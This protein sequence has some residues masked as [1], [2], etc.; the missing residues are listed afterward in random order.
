MPGLYTP[1]APAH[2][3]R[4]VSLGSL[5]TALR[6][7]GGGAITIF[8]LIGLA[9]LGDDLDKWS[10]WLGFLGGRTGWIA[11]TVLGLALLLLPVDA[12][13]RAKKRT[14]F[15]PPEDG[16]PSVEES[17]DGLPKD[18]PEPGL[19]SEPEPAVKSL[20]GQER[21]PSAERRIVDVTPQYL[22]GLF[23]SYTS[24]QAN[25]LAKP[26]IGKW[27]KVSGTLRN[28]GSFTSFSQV[29]FESKL[30]DAVVFMLFRDEDYVANRL[31]VLKKGDRITV[32]GQID[33]V[34]P[35]AVQ[36]DDCELID[37]EQ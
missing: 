2:Y 6:R 13:A 36:L 14:G 3:Y 20:S 22:A 29:T 26:F 27:M 5:V 34:E 12:L 30:G 15:T 25:S 16:R 24:I 8:G 17:S 1:R 21:A 28:V 23:E 31:A 9:G 33:R 32:L 4:G 10:S 7:V 11:P 19:A 35:S 18:S 37:A